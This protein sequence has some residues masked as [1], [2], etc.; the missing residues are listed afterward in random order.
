MEVHVVADHSALYYLQQSDMLLFEPMVALK[1]GGCI[2]EPV[3]FTLLL[4][5]KQLQIP[6]IA[7]VRPAQICDNPI[8]IPLRSPNELNCNF[9]NWGESDVVLPG[10]IEA[11]GDLIT[12]FAE[13]KGFVRPESLYKVQREIE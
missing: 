2:V 7:L 8:T 4:L 12:W 3:T 10:G 1:S 9:D 13:P 5:A 6:T 11:S